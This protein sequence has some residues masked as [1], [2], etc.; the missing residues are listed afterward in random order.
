MPFRVNTITFAP[1]YSEFNQGNFRDLA[2]YS[3]KTKWYYSGTAVAIEFLQNRVSAEEVHAFRKIIIK[4]QRKSVASPERHGRG[5]IPY[6]VENPKL[7]VERHVDIFSSLLPIGWGNIVRPLDHNSI[8]LRGEDALLALNA[9][10]EEANALPGLDMPMT[11][12]KLVFNGKQRETM[13]VWRIVLLAVD[14]YE[15]MTECCRRGYI[16]LPDRSED[17]CP[18]RHFALPCHLPP[19][20]AHAIHDI[21][22]GS[23]IVYF[24]GDPGHLSD[25]ESMIASRH[26]WSVPQ[27]RF[28][29][30]EKVIEQPL[31][32]PK[33]WR[34]GLHIDYQ[35][36]R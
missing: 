27:W 15:A 19:T 20:F 35:L 25:R 3:K 9:W 30:E 31:P 32:L 28:E 17:S 12:Y 6:C 14:L 23:S 26:D 24:D 29:W 34:E 18:A 10:L 5:L 36:R 7:S 2:K 11:T 21:L 16:Q 4:E 13:R 1:G 33:G 8:S 22:R